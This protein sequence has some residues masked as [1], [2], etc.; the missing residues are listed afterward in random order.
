M[1]SILKA[2][3]KLE[4]ERTPT[5]GR[6][7][8][9]ARYEKRPAGVSRRNKSLLVL[10][11]GILIGVFS[12]GG[13]MMLSGE[14]EVNKNQTAINASGESPAT[15]EQKL[16]SQTAAASIKKNFRQEPERGSARQPDSG[17]SVAAGDEPALLPPVKTSAK[18]PA[19]TSV[20]AP[21]HPAVAVK[22]EPVASAHVETEQ[23]REVR[24]PATDVAAVKSGSPQAAKPPLAKVTEIYFQP[25]GG[26]MAVVDDLPV[27][28]GTTVNGA[29]VDK[30]L[31]DRVRFLVDGRP[32]EILLER[33]P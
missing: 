9:V 18:T 25:G 1:S 2:L 3:K 32:V 20:K 29:L 15:V 24:M 21:G 23:V 4:D 7:E 30:I 6:P 26:S 17:L 10:A 11:C 12:A 22:P 8:Y 16:G 31:T 5:A 13:W 19:K 14:G 33:T 27:M 28:E